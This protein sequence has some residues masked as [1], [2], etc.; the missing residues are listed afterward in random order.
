[1]R[2]VARLHPC[3]QNHRFV[4]ANVSVEIGRKRGNLGRVVALQFL[5]FAAQQPGKSPRQAVEW[6]QA[7]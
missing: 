2:K 5:R 6:P 3:T 1:M 4:L 7:K